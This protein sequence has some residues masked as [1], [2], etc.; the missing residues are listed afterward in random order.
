MKILVTKYEDHVEL[1]IRDES[2]VN[3]ESFVFT[4]EKAHMA[5]IQGMNCM[6]R[7]TNKAVQ[8]IP[9]DYTSFRA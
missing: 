3:L 1:V 2:G 5:F 6:K 9:T 4:D 7:L 8:S